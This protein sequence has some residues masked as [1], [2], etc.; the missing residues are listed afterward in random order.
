MGGIL[1]I[2]QS[3]VD[4]SKENQ[5]NAVKTEDDGLA[6]PKTTH[7]SVNYKGT[8]HISPSIITAPDLVTLEK[9]LSTFDKTAAI[10][11]DVDETLVF[12]RDAPFIYGMPK[13]DA[14]VKKH[15]NG[16]NPDSCFS[17]LKKE[18]GELME[19]DYYDSPVELVDVGLPAL[20]TKL[21]SKG[22][23]IYAL[24]SR[25]AEHYH[26][27][28]LLSELKSLFPKLPFNDVKALKT[29]AVVENVIFGNYGDKGIIM[30]EI[31]ETKRSAVLIDNS[32]SKCKAAFN[33][34]YDAVH[35]T[36]AF[37]HGNTEKMRAAFCRY[38][39]SMGQNCE[40][41]KENEDNFKSD[42]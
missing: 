40:F 22:H 39:S 31:L 9:N 26:T 12:P 3:I 2:K 5:C 19:K 1:S 4:K 16:D 6:D 27:P 10:F 34:G 29:A 38:M 33:A 36:L 20:L 24:T 21:K 30:Q 23:D 18:L 17:K 7:N 41:C 32:K 11:F 25:S 35:F 13:T 8:S 37:N 15:T 28:T 14:F 42:E